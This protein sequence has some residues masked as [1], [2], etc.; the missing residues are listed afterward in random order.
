MTRIAYFQP[1]SGISGDMALGA[2]VD[3]GVSLPE[4]SRQLEALHLPGW[5][6][7]HESVYRGAFRASR[8]RVLLENDAATAQ[9]HPHQHRSSQVH[10]AGEHE[11]EHSH[12]HQHGHAHAHEHELH[13][14]GGDGAPGQEDRSLSTIRRLINASEI[15]PEV[16]SQAIA[17]FERLGSAEA[18]VH[19]IP[20]EQ[21]HFHEVGAI[22]SIIDIVGVCLG[23]HLLGVDAVHS[24]PVTVGTGYVR[25]DHGRMPLPAPATAELLLGFPIEQRDSRAELTT[26]TGAALLTT[27][28]AGF[29]TMPRGSITKIGYGAG[30]DRPGAVPNVLRLFLLDS[31]ETPHGDRVVVLATNIDDLSPEWLA[32]VVEETFA[33]GALDV[34]LTPIL[35]KKGRAAH[36]LKAIV[37]ESKREEVIH[38]LFRQGATLGVRITETD[39]ATL[40]RRQ[41]EVQTSWGPVRVKI[42]TFCGAEVSVAPEF[43]DLQA[44]ARKAKRSIREVHQLVMATISA[45]GTTSGT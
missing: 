33:A 23:L 37:K 27:L 18:K 11:H 2:L 26:P 21:V 12:S 35:M 30:D 41:I 15:P 20:V 32:H 6:L 44:V 24:A 3:A 13:P 45:D 1:F 5:R 16:K 36:E 29:G 25:G 7:A 8:I 34:W 38:A 19:G 28:G 22:D 42:G 39:R 40:Q 31:A 9:G 17:V 4:L 10:D 43:D 14:P